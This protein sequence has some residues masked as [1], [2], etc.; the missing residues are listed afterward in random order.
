MNGSRVFVLALVCLV[1][2]GCNDDKSK[3]QAVARKPFPNPSPVVG[4]VLKSVSMQPTMESPFGV[5]AGDTLTAKPE[6][7]TSGINYKW[8]VDEHAV[9]TTKTYRVDNRD[10]MKVVRVCA[11]TAANEIC[12]YGMKVI[13]QHPITGDMG[14]V[15][16]APPK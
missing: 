15:V 1:T 7:A 6:G 3:N 10:W 12:S 13:P 9:A 16:P 5:F 8:K 14:Q 2:F 11:S 4:E